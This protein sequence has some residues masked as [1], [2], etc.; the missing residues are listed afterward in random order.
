VNNDLAGYIARTPERFVPNQMRGK[1]LEAEHFVRYHWVAP[2]AAGERVLDAGCGLGYG[3]AILAGGG[4]ASVTGVDLAES[5]LEAARPDMPPGTELLK[6]DINELPFETGSFDLVVCFETIEH[7]QDADRGLD[8]LSRVLADGGRLCLSSPNRL[9]STG[10]NPHHVREYSPKELH[11]MLERRFPHVRLMYQDTWHTSAL[12]AQ[13]SYEID[14]GEEV[15]GARARSLGRR[16]LGRAQFIVGLASTSELPP[17][18]ELAILGQAEEPKELQELFERQRAAI[19]D[20]EAQE[21]SQLLHM[22]RLERERLEL[23]ESLVSA[24]AAV[25]HAAETAEHAAEMETIAAEKH[26]AEAA[27]LR[28][29]TEHLWWLVQAMRSSVS[30]RITAPLRALSKLRRGRSDDLLRGLRPRN[31]WTDRLT[32]VRASARSRILQAWES[33]PRLAD[34]RHPRLWLRGLRMHRDLWS[35]GYTMLYPARARTLLRLASIADRRGVPGALVDCG[36]YNGGS[37]AMLSAGSPERAVWAF[38]SFQGLPEPGPLDVESGIAGTCQGH[39]ARLREAVARHGSPQRLQVRPG[40]FD[41]TLLDA[42]D[43]VGQIAVL[44]IDADLHGSVK[45]A[46]EAFYPSVSPGGVIVIDDY[47]ARPGARIVTDDFRQKVGDSARLVRID[48]TGR[49]WRKPGA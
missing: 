44:H 23:R 25:A 28:Q 4:A 8:E 29:Q 38:D 47:G 7:L 45:L 32:V 43:E 35:G 18:D 9:V 46:L 6:A 3:T 31:P 10:N 33:L 15:P 40:W 14:E 1:M 39:E 17:L 11:D 19:E 16:E 30:W 36:A 27:E 22:R 24:E 49:W 21:R 2:M 12:L 34:L 37:T 42:V 13:E 26:A 5:V 41:E 48:Q 20:H